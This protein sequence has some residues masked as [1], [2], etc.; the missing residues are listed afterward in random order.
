MTDIVVRLREFGRHVEGN[1]GVLGA[2]DGKLELEAAD[3]IE[4]L[5]ALERERT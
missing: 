1:H 2:T 5:R 3:E 4:R